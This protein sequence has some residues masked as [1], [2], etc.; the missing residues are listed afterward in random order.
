M[1]I[2]AFE[3]ADLAS[4]MR[5]WK[6][7][8]GPSHAFLPRQFLR[9]TGRSLREGFRAENTFV[10]DETGVRGFVCVANCHVNALFVDPP[11]QG[12][13]IGAKLLT[14]AKGLTRELRLTVFTENTRGILFYHRE[15]FFV[16]RRWFYQAARNEML[17]MKWTP[18]WREERKR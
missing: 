11:H 10:F 3:A 1:V 8:C 17:V 16:V 14:H 7:S 4:V 2:R 13:G 18:D 12:R 5:V 9:M 15:D 6:D